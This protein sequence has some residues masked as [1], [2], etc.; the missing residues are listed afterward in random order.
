M[1]LLRLAHPFQSSTL[2]PTSFI[3]RNKYNILKTKEERN[4]ENWWDN[5]FNVNYVSILRDSRGGKFVFS[6]FDSNQIG[7]S[8]FLDDEI[9]DDDE[10]E[11]LT[12]KSQFGT[13]QYWDQTY[14][15]RGDFPME[16]Y[17][18]YYGWDDTIKT[19]WM[20]YVLPNLTPPIT[21]K[22]EIAN[23]CSEEKCY[24]PKESKIL[25]PGIGNDSVLLDLYGSGWKKLTAFDYSK[26]SI[27]RQYDII[28]TT[29]VEKGVKDGNVNLYVMDAT[30][31]KENEIIKKYNVMKE[32][33]D[34]NDQDLDTDWTDEFDI[35]FE[36][37]ALD[38]IYL[39]CSEHDERVQAAVSELS[40]V[41]HKGGI[42]VS[43]SGVVTEQLRR[44][45][46]ST[47]EWEWIRDGSDDLQAG[48]FVWKKL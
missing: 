36:K 15:G 48:C 37:G 35:V 20:D 16:E 27:E 17:S 11:E 28:S 32:K 4:C 22:G 43:V 24:D 42:F 19:I 31:L 40:R 10:E 29:N 26:H 47:E 7:E 8:Y 18:W 6:A 1:Q 14:I 21:I 25:I 9:E 38:A 3:R 39:S 2:T 30:D 34:I 45:M 41:L 12:P 13:R 23:T 44:Q 46:F 33:L 5:Y